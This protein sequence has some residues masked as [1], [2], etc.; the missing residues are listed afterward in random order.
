M[1]MKQELIWL[2]QRIPYGMV[3]SYGELAIQLDKQYGIHTSGWLVGRMLSSMS[4]VESKF[5]QDLDCFVPRNDICPRWRVINKQWV[6]SALKLWQ[7]WLD[8]IRLLETESIQVVDGQVDMKVY[9]YN[10]W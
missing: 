7:K 4:P 10:F 8:Q 1:T 6:I 3:V 9:E 5:T 2:I